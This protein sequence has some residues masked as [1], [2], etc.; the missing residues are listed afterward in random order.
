MSSVSCS[1]I[2]ATNPAFFSVETADLRSWPS[3]SG[4]AIAPLEKR[5][6]AIQ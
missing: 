6:E 3:T 2:E 4:T 1:V 5:L